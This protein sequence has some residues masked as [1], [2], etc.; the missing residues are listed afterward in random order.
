MTSSFQSAAYTPADQA[1]L[2]GLAAAE[3][4]AKH[5]GQGNCVCGFP[6]EVAWHSELD[7]WFEVEEYVCVACSARKG[8][9]VTHK[10]VRN[11]WPPEKPLPP[12]SLEHTTTRVA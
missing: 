10:I 3:E 8:E 5:S 12:F 1:L 6:I 11:T 9:Q 2:M 4:Q 7:G